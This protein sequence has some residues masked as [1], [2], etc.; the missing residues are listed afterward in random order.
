MLSKNYWRISPITLRIL[1]V[2]VGALLILGFGLLYSGQ[3]E[4]E[5]I[6]TELNA[7][8][9]EGRLLAAALAEGGA[10]DN[11]EG[12]RILAEDLSRH[13]LR[14]L[15][16]ENPH[17]TILF[18]KV[19]EAVLDS[20]QLLGPG[21]IVEMVPLEAPFATWPMHEKARFYMQ[22]FLDLLP[23]RLRLP[24]FPRQLD[25]RAQAYPGILETLNGETFS[26][27][28]RDADGK[29][30]LTA[31]LPIQNLKNVLGAVLL[32]QGGDSIDMAVREVQFTV[33]SFFFTPC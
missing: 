25:N 6:R 24:L 3:Y 14:K 1:A 19:G 23:I 5:L 28:W 27:A 13:M 22:G 15:S 2:N 31:S 33:I 20:H 9:A 29:I 30:M 7:L 26:H 17:R 4:R 16:E 12:D 10:R 11:A 32:I 18:T 8:V 21:G